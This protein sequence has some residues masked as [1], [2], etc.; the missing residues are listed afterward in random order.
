MIND[1]LLHSK[2]KHT[3]NKENLRTRENICKQGDQQK[4]FSSKI[5]KQ[6][7]NIDTNNP[8]KKCRIPKQTFIQKIQNGYKAHMKAA[9]TSQIIRDMQGKATMR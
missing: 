5:Y 1:K 9:P 3:Q 6:L 7:N 2:E 4:G 8:I